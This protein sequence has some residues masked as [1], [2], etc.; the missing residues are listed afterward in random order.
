MECDY[1]RDF[2]LMIGFIE[3]LHFV[4][5]SKDYVVT[6]VHTSHISIGHT[7]SSRSVIV[8]TNRC[9]VAASNG[10]CCDVYGMTLD[11]FRIDDRIY[12]TL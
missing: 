12:W 7:R 2:G 6:I 5:T 10:G 1:R 11:G 3:L 9:S 4:T 8:F